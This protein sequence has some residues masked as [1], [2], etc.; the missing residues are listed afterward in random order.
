MENRASEDDDEGYCN[1]GID[2][3]RM[4][5]RDIV[6]WESSNVGGKMLQVIVLLVFL[7]MIIKMDDKYDNYGHNENDDQNL[8]ITEM[9][10]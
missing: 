7:V 2:Q 10:R 8:I 1:W 5:R 9:A 4:M 6:I 3:V